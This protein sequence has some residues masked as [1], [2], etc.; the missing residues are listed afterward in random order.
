MADL[1][2]PE[3]KPKTLNGRRQQMLV[4][5]IVLAMAAGLVWLAAPRA[6][7]GYERAEHE[8]VLFS[9]GFGRNVDEARIVDAARDYQ[10]SLRYHVDGRTLS[11]LAA[12]WMRLARQEGYDTRRGASLLDLAQT[13]DRQALRQSPSLTRSWSRLTLAAMLE[14]PR[15]SRVPGL[16]TLAVATAPDNSRVMRIRLFGAMM[17]W[18]RL[19][20]DQRAIVGEQI[21]YAARMSMLELVLTANRFNRISAVREALAVEPALLRRFDVEIS[22]R[23]SR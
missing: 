15:H 16:L 10:S 3:A 12:M 1:P 8:R 9:L 13:A 18:D 5:A 17:N 7:A 14:D 20:A 4:G 2:A 6:L 21:V 22:R 11:D 19:S 23:I